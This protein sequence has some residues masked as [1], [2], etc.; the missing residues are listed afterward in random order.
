M[1]CRAIKIYGVKTRWEDSF[2]RLN[3]VKEVIAVQEIPIQGDRLAAVC[4]AG[5]HQLIGAV[6][7]LEYW[8]QINLTTDAALR[9]GLE[10]ILASGVRL[11]LLHCACQ[12]MV[13]VQVMRFL[14]RIYHGVGARNLRRSGDACPARHEYRINLQLV[15]AACIRVGSALNGGLAHGMPRQARS[16]LRVSALDQ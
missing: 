6:S 14:I 9:E 16:G 1:D 10:A 5:P 12:I 2:D 7:R 4:R 8:L 3:L 15:D 11:L 13:Q